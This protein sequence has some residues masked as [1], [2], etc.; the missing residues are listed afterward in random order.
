MNRSLWVLGGVA[1]VLLAS[2]ATA[3]TVRG[4]AQGTRV[5]VTVGMRRVTGS[6]MASSG[7]SLKWVPDGSAQPVWLTWARVD[8]LEVSQGRHGHA[9][10][11]LAIGLVGGA[12]LGA[13][14]GAAFGDPGFFS[15]GDIATFGAI[16]GAP[17]GALVGA[18][19]GSAVR[20]ER[21]EPRVMA[22]A[23][24]G[25]SGNLVVGLSLAL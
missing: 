24:Q 1:T 7:D 23:R 22:R 10:A 5:R 16:I 21:W 4:I 2:R 13:G 12:A 19:V 18:A 6:V 14:A 8:Q 25:L 15:R 3:Q 9:W 11:G 20:T 17:L